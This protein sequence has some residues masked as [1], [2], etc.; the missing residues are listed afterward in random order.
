MNVSS[1]I[2]GSQP[3]KKRTVII[4]DIRSMLLYSPRKNM[5]KMMDEYSTL[6]PAT[7]SASASGRSKGAL[8]V[9]A[10]METKKIAAHGRSGAANQTVRSWAK[11]ISVKF[12]EPANNITGRMVSPIE[13]S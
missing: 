7:S 12:E 13:T 10:N 9:S 5:A 1:E 6:Y 11:I 2:I 4:A 3:P 8:F